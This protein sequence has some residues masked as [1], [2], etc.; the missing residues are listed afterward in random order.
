MRIGELAKRSG[1]TVETLRF[2]ERAGVLG[3]V[4]RDASGYRVYDEQAFRTLVT[5][6][7]AQ[8]AGLR[9]EDIAKILDASESTSPKARVTILARLVDERLALLRS[10]I[11]QI[12]GTIERLVALRQ[13]PFDGECVIPTAFVDDLVRSHQKKAAP[14]RGRPRQVRRKLA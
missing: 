1:L 8:D 2:Y 13:I 7:W 6:R 4:T 12:E 5:V 3:S 14:R 11:E 10:Q 9:L